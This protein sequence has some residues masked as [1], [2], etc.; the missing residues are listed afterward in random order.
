M[1]LHNISETNLT[2]CIHYHEWQMLM[3][4]HGWQYLTCKRS[5]NYVLT[6]NANV[7]RIKRIFPGTVF[8]WW[9]LKFLVT[10]EKNPL[11]SFW[12]L[13]YAKNPYINCTLQKY[14]ISNKPCCK[15]VP[16]LSH[17]DVAEKRECRL[18][19]DERATGCSIGLKRFGLKKVSLM[20]SKKF[21]Y[22]TYFKIERENAACRGPSGRRAA[23][24]IILYNI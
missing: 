4:S 16:T 10:A 14:N 9:F 6:N 3:G 1:K 20:V 8:T 11:W 18:P 21:W 24:S 12:Q 13:P 15:F 2:K 7:L 19:R 17:K 5:I 23:S 22:F